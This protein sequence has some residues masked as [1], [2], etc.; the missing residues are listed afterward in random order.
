MKDKAVCHRHEAVHTDHI[1][2]LYLRQEMN[3]VST[4]VDPEP[5]LVVHQIKVVCFVENE[6]PNWT[7]CVL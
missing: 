4:A 2:S 7:V 6:S 1:F 5:I 3:I